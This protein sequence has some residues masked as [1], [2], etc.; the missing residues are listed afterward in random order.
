MPAKFA[1]EELS[2]EKA[3]DGH[4]LNHTSVTH[5]PKYRALRT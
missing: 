3:E 4:N 5:L 1:R 2:K